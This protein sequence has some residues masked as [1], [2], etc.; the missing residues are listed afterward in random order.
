MR[1]VQPQVRRSTSAGWPTYDSGVTEAPQPVSSDQQMWRI[2]AHASAYI[3]VIGIPSLVGPLVVWLLR[4][5]DP[6]VEPHARAA[7]NFQLSLLIYT[8]AGIVLGFLFAITIVGLVLTAVIVIFLV[9]LV[10]LELL[11]ALLASLAASK[12]EWYDYPLSLELIRG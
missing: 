10:I 1:A 3:Q 9:V 4:R 5:D 6:V 7:L 8:V 12:G 2:L 11:F